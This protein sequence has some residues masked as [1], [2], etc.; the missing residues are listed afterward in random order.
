MS[1]PKQPAKTFGGGQ[2]KSIRPDSDLSNVVYG[3]IQPQA[4]PLEEVVLGALLI[5]KDA[6]ALIMDI[7]NSQ[8]FYKRAHQIIYEA[9][10]QLFEQSQPIDLLTVNESLTK[11]GQIEEIGGV[12]YL[13][14]LSNK[15]GSSANIEFHARIIAQKFI[16]RE[17]IR[18]STSIINDSSKTQKTSLNFLMMQ[19]VICLRS[20]NKT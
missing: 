12:T 10:L 4:L 11:S 20:H 14:D 19:R 6:L 1:E 16:Q 9:M 7:I 15:V 18:V 13:I 8:T 3:K 2:L 17:L 5:D